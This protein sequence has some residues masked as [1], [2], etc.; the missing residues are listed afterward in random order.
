M[1]AKD[2]RVKGIGLGFETSAAKSANVLSEL[3]KMKKNTHLTKKE[4]KEQTE[5]K[6]R[7]ESKSDL[8][9]GAIDK[10]SAIEFKD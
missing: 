2:D 5:S 10:K 1:Q 4:E 3:A 7:K 9:K 6:E 8:M